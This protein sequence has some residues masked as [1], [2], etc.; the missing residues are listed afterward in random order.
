MWVSIKN[1][2]LAAG[3]AFA[4]LAS[5]DGAF[6]QAQQPAAANDQLLLQQMQGQVAGRVS[7]PDAK[8]G[9]LIQ[10][11]GR[12]WRELRE[13]PVKTVGG[14]IIIAIVLALCAFFLV[15]GRIRIDAGPSSKRITRFNGVERFAHWLTAVSFIVL[16]LTGLNLVFGRALLLP[17]IGPEAFTA[18]TQVGKL[19][20][21]Y[22]SFAFV[23]GIV[24]MLVLWLQH[25]IPNRL[26]I[27]W[28]K[29]GGGLLKKG[30]HPPSGKFN[31]GQK[32]IFWAVVLG[33]AAVSVTG[34]I[35][36]FPFYFTD[37]A[38]M[39]LSQVIHAVV[40]LVLIAVIIAHIYIGSIGME[41]A[42]DAMGTGDVDLNWAKEHHSLWVEELTGKKAS[43]AGDD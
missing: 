14:A 16:G 25:N 17:L 30:V 42:F 15:R 7:I 3:L 2:L 21:N 10:P 18:L 37:M 13:G 39:Q 23:L 29:Q 43:H 1:V 40:A 34:Y 28:L 36:M 24:M 22:L 11:Q 35:L 27:E 9:L 4:V 41:G 19:A 8:S 5:A 33:G 31:G 38:G 26:D 20:H 12:E 32:L 6:A